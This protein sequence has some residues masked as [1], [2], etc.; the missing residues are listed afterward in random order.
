H[1]RFSRDWSSDVCSYDLP[2]SLSAE[3][4]RAE[5]EKV[6]AAVTLPDD[7]S[8]ATARGQYDGGWQGGQEV[9][10]FLEEDGMNPDSI[11][12]TYAAIRSEERRVGKECRARGSR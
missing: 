12:E 5:K 11:T 3:N 9:C 1:T 7:L 8:L 6:L 2:I 4:L 10:G